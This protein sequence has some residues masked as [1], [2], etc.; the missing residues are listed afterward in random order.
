MATAADSRKRKHSSA[1]RQNA[2]NL[3]SSTP[4][5]EASEEFKVQSITRHRVRRI[6]TGEVR[7]EFYVKWIGHKKGSWEPME[8]LCEKCALLFERFQNASHKKMMKSQERVLGKAPNPDTTP[9]FPQISQQFLNGFTNATESVPNGTEVV[10]DISAEIRGQDS[11]KLW[12]VTFVGKP[13]AM[14]IRKCVME[15]YFP[16]DAAFFN[17]YLL[18]K[19]KK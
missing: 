17:K 12:I 18:S 11:V 13:G 19:A 5:V 8:V 9:K 6:E 7:T 2:E 15:Y 3:S 1:D 16:Y 14:F 4:P 10:Q